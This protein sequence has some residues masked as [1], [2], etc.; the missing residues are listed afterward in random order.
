MEIFIMGDFNVDIL[1]FENQNAISIIEDL[2]A[3]VFS[4]MIT[5]PTRHAKNS[6][7]SLK[8]NIYTNSKCIAET[9]NITLNE[10][11]HDLVYIIRKKA[12]S[13]HVK[14]SFR[15]RSYQQYNKELFQELFQA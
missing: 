6:Q 15:G 2:Q 4:Q 11:D 9:G 3:Y 10:S 7:S 1:N 13:D 8:D 12:K 5:D 14:L